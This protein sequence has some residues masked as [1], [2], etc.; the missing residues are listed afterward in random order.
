MPNPR[1]LFATSEMAPLVKTGGLADVSASLP[2]ALRDLGCD[3][4]IL[5]PGYRDARRVE[6][7]GR[8]VGT[9]RIQGHTVEFREYPVPGLPPVWLV[10][11]PELFDRPGNPYLGPDGQD[12]PDNVD[13]FALFGQAVAEAALTGLGGFRPDVV[14]LNDWQT[15]LAGALIARVARRPATLFTIHNLHF[16]GL[17]DAVHL[18]RLGLPAD[19]ASVDA[20]EFHGRISFIK[21]GIVFAD[22]ITTVSPGYAR[23]IQTPEHG[24][25]LDGLIRHRA[26]VLEGILNGIDTGVWNPAT[27]GLIPVRY[28]VHTLDRKR[29]DKRALE[30]AVGLDTGDGPLLGMVSRLTDQKG[31]DLVL[32][33]V[34]ALTR[35][36]AR[37]A[38]LGSGSGRY[39]DALADAARRYRGRVAFVNAYSEPLAHLVEAGADIFLMPSRF[40][41][42]GLNQMFSMAYGTLPVVRRTGGL[43]DTVVPANAPDG[44]GRRDGT[45][46]AF[47]RA[48]AA[49]LLAAVEDALAWFGDARAWRRLQVNAMCQDFS[50]GASSAA[51]LRLYRRLAAPA[52]TEAGP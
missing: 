27:D 11:C 23:E 31:I 45:G 52:G 13:R 8:L 12:W 28:D 44:S 21:G 25:G 19:L 4:R 39:Q 15:G 17:F 26:A 37:L 7:D 3:V 32:E 29:L 22:A 14:H 6:G 40:E 9:A 51:Y 38:V 18:A 2:K 36:G 43:R 41:P 47:D 1:V 34:P 49:S 10:C 42:C 33:I 50:W 30:G 16:H 35:L 48:D 5:L 24:A 46:F 20:L